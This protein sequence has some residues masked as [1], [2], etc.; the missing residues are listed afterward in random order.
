MHMTES[1]S[2]IGKLWD[3]YLVKCLTH[4]LTPFSQMRTELKVLVYD[5]GGGTLDTSLLYMNGN[6]A[7]RPQE[8]NLGSRCLVIQLREKMKFETIIDI[9][10]NSRGFSFSMDFAWDFQGISTAFAWGECTECGWRWPPRRVRLWYSAAWR[11][12]SS[13]SFVSMRTLKHYPAEITMWSSFSPHFFALWMTSKDLAWLR[14]T[15]T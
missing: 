4:I 5:I 2:K 12:F 11:K 8:K 10:A 9:I 7:S 3:L 6:A 1:R 14:M 15:E 13:L